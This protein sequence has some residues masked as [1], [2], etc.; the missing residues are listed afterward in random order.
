MISQQKSTLLRPGKHPVFKFPNAKH[1]I[2]IMFYIYHNYFLLIISVLRKGKNVV[3]GFVLSESFTATYITAKK[4][5]GKKE[6]LHG[7]CFSPVN[8]K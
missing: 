5:N 6:D 1:M 2:Y 7:H 4:Q 8:R 3:F